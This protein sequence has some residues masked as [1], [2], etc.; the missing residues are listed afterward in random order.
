MPPKPE[1]LTKV[2][3]PGV[4]TA[5]Y[6]VPGEKIS[7]KPVWMCRCVCGRE[8]KVM[9]SCLK[10]GDVK[11]CGQCDT[12]PRG[13]RA[14]KDYRQPVENQSHGVVNVSEAKKEMRV[15]PEIAKY[16][17]QQPDKKFRKRKETVAEIAER[18]ARYCG[19]GRW[20]Y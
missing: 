11:S 9:S 10:W 8:K 17:T 6:I 5:L 16:E 4:L 19:A 2:K 3:L 15:D 13:G 20:N 7:G 12:I 1:D 18:E 14:H